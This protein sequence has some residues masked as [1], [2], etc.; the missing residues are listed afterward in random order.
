M[1]AIVD[2]TDG[3]RHA[4]GD[5]DEWFVEPG[6]VRYRAKDRIG[7]NAKS[8]EDFK[9]PISKSSEATNIEQHEAH[10]DDRHKKP[11][12]RQRTCAG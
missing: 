3:E 9:K 8:K 1:N 2:P 12:Y 6:R 5:P 11:A 7:H 4:G 10:S